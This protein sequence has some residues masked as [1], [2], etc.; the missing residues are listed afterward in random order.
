MITLRFVSHPGPFD[1]LVRAAQLGY[2]A[3]HV[4][5]L[6]PDGTFISSRF[7]DGVQVRPRNYD[8]GKFTREQWFSIVSTKDEASRF[9]D[10][11]RSQIGKPYDALAIVAFLLGRDWQASDSWFCSELPAAALS[12]CGLFPKMLAVGFNRITPRDLALVTS[13]LVDEAGQ[14]GR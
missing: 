11:M 13:A 3:S 9:Y 7:W 5:A 8:A 6:M 2:W 14:N 4:D 1:L 12:A 10:F